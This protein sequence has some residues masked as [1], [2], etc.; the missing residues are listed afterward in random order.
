M[1]KI[2]KGR[3]WVGGYELFFL[4]S[5]IQVWKDG[6]VVEVLY[7]LVF[8]GLKERV[9]GKGRQSLWVVFKLLV[10][11]GFQSEWVDRVF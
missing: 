5:F 7:C 1:E 2:G 3:K 9:D 4:Q 11:S 8:Y 10:S 6:D